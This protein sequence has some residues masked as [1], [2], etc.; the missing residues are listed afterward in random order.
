[1]RYEEFISRVAQRADLTTDE[2]V[3]AVAAVLGTLAERIGPEEAADTASQLP[4]EL[5]A[6]LA[7]PPV[8]K[9]FGAREFVRRVA[10]RTGFDDDRAKSAARAIFA[11]LHEAVSHGELADWEPDLSTD[12]V[13]IGARH[14]D[15]GR[16][17]RS[18]PPGTPGR[19]AVVGE[20][21]FVRAVEERAGV[22]ER[23]A[24]RAIEAVLETFGERI[25]G[26]Q[27]NDLA[28]QLPEVAAEPL[29][30]AGGDP[31]AIAVDE[32]V[33]RVAEREGVPEVV[34]R[35]HARAVLTTLRE[36][37][38]VDEWRD[39]VSELPRE[40]DEQLLSDAFVAS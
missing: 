12:Y 31:A 23:G 24:R 18:A 16:P 34:A 26:G 25:A 19:G 40:Y 35:E 20:R 32:F 2:A 17:P 9:Q 27:A 10:H 15:V 4:K 11:T 8:P 5:Q 14:A 7:A 13:D 33:R 30:R 38:T 22:D 3:S 21:E 36:S 29:L 6:A 1:M 28:R 39:T 37:V